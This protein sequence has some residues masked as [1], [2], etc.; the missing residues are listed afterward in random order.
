MDVTLTDCLFRRRLL[1]SSSHIALQYAN[2]TQSFNL[3]ELA[4][5]AAPAPLP[6][7]VNVSVSVVNNTS[8]GA[9]ASTHN[10]TDANGILVDTSSRRRSLLQGRS[11]LQSST[12]THLQVSALSCML[13]ARQHSCC[14]LLGQG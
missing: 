13:L 7:N 10:A 3:S 4:P 12:G 1:T 8:A 5:G 2:G 11:L 9:P 6:E 14:S